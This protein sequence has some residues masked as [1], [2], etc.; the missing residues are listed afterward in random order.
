MEG[1]TI[2]RSLLVN[3]PLAKALADLLLPSSDEQESTA[4]ATMRFVNTA[5]L[6]HKNEF[7]LYVERE[8][9]A[10]S[11]VI[12]RLKSNER[13]QEVFGRRVCG[14]VSL[15][16]SEVIPGW[17]LLLRTTVGPDGTEGARYVVLLRKKDSPSDDKSAVR[18]RAF[19]SDE[20]GIIYEGKL[21][22]DFRSEALPTTLA[23]V[24]WDAQAIGQPTHTRHLQ[25]FVKA[26]ALFWVYCESVDSCYLCPPPPY[27][28]GV[29]CS[30]F[31]ACCCGGQVCRESPGT[32][33][34]CNIGCQSCPWCCSWY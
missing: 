27:C 2:L 25:G 22:A 23:A 8:Q 29:C 3:V 7:G 21:L 4:V 33:N 1:R 14:K 13:A 10:T 9:L 20:S 28:F 15:A 24:K 26:A 18:V 16:Q 32:L 30:S 6:W 11:P 17:E 12:D 31:P 19:G 5:E 34:C